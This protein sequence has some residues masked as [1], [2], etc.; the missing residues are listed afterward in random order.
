MCIGM[1]V[2][3]VCYVGVIVVLE[4]K[5]K[6]AKSGVRSPPGFAKGRNFFGEKTREPDFALFLFSSKTTITPT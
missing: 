1:W 2:W 6:R 3:I 4:E 5:R